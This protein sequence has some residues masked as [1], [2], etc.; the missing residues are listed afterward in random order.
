M[1]IKKNFIDLDLHIKK[2]TIF[3]CKNFRLKFVLKKYLS[4]ATHIERKR[5]IKQSIAVFIE[6]KVEGQMN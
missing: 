1:E 4:L 2:K 5:E 3:F 6:K